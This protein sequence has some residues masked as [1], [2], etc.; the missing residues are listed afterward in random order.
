MER[1]GEKAMAQIET[2]TPSP[3]VVAHPACECWEGIKSLSLAACLLND[4]LVLDANQRFKNF[5]GYDPAIHGPFSENRLT[6]RGDSLRESIQPTALRDSSGRTKWCRIRCD[7]FDDFTIWIF[8]DA[9]AER[10]LAERVARMENRIKLEVEK[11]T[12]TLRRTNAE[13][14]R[15]LERARVFDVGLTQSREKYRVLFQNSQAGIAFVDDSGNLSQVNPAM[16]LL[17]SS[18]NKID[19]RRLAALPLCRMNGCAEP[20]SLDELARYLVFDVRGEQECLVTI[21]KQT[22]TFIWVEVRCTRMHVR[23]FSAALTFRDRTEEI[24][25]ARREAEQRHQLNRM[26]RISLAGHLG[27]AMAHELGQPLT[28]CMNYTGG[29][30][31]I[32]QSENSSPSILHGLAQIRKELTRASNVL[33]SMRQFVSNHS[34]VCKPICVNTLIRDTGSLL[35]ANLRDGGVALELDLPL[36]DN[37]CV[38]GNSVEI[39]QVLVNLVM[40]AFDSIHEASPLHP[41][42]C[43]GAV[44]TQ[45]QMIECHITDNG[46]GIAPETIEK[47]FTP[48]LTTKIDGLGLGLSMCRNII[49]SHGGQ[50]WADSEKG[51]GATLRFTLPLHRRGET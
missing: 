25:I 18:R 39:Q 13:Y 51:K 24:M 22:G 7:K 9:S 1:I 37:L 12:V 31:K 47:L 8:E 42:I 45:N 20:V 27:S 43:I 15:E 50:I 28:A 17:L 3:P 10:A 41:T 2:L 14:R 33:K 11:R 46:L 21:E 48:Y 34:P 29:L 32:L 36:K 38:N 26:G 49:E 35:E 4:G 44:R 30:E 23:D 19:F 6:S 40:N 5:F 16:R